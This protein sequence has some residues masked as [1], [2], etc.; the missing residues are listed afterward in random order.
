MNKNQEEKTMRFYTTPMNL[1]KRSN[2]KSRKTNGTSIT[3][4][5]KNAHLSMGIM[6]K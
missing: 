1:N 5:Y 3:I 4:A 6:C 2:K